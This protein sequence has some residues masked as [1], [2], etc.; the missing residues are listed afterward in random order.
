[1]G[2]V[3]AY[4]GAL[5]VHKEM[6]DVDA[7][8]KF[9]EEQR[10]KH[11]DSKIVLHFRISTQG[12][13]KISNNHPFLV[14]DTVAFA[15]NGIISGMGTEGDLSDTRIYNKRV[16]QKMP[17]GFHRNKTILKL[18]AAFG[19][20]YN[21]FVFLDN[22]NHS[23]IIG[24][25]KGDW[26]EKKENWFSN[27]HWKYRTNEY[28]GMYGGWGSYGGYEKT[29]IGFKQERERQ[30]KNEMLH[31]KWER[32]GWVLNEQGVY[33]YAPGSAG[34]YKGLYDRDYSSWD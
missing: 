28:G 26:D 34:G 22:E 6:K 29:T 12:G 23:T 18:L 2:M 24:E 32:E 11:P 5:H 20:S 33:V 25:N 15:H 1:M 9:Y 27:L 31:K 16:L 3:L 8:F 4:E 13:V 10:T 30:P 7:F 14:D 19:G 17:K 21:K